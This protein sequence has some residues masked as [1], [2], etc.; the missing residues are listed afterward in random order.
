MFFSGGK[1]GGFAF[2]KEFYDGYV[3]YICG[4]NSG[5]VCGVTQMTDF[6]ASYEEAVEYKLQACGEFMGAVETE[7]E[8][9]TCSDTD[10]CTVFFTALEEFEFPNCTLKGA[11]LEERFLQMYDEDLA[12]YEEAVAEMCSFGQKNNPASFAVILT[13]LLL[14]LYLSM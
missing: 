14:L 11:N 8:D 9:I 12:V 4:S 10:A 3:A 1:K 2:F 6:T 13:G 5:G 7:Q